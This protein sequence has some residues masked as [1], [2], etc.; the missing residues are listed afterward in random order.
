MFGSNAEQEELFLKFKHIGLLAAREGLTFDG[1][2]SVT[3]DEETHL[4]Q[5][6]FSRENSLPG[7]HPLVL[8]CAGKCLV[9]ATAGPNSIDYK[10]RVKGS[11]V[12]LRL[13]CIA[14]LAGFSIATQQLKEV[15]ENAVNYAR[16]QLNALASG[17]V[18]QGL[19]VTLEN[20]VYRVSA[21]GVLIDSINVE[22][23]AS[24]GLP[25]ANARFKAQAYTCENLPV[26]STWEK[27]ARFIKHMV[28]PTL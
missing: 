25:G 13:D 20:G 8:Q 23:I 16:F 10:N 1:V 21:R 17:F 26:F 28:T 6:T 12:E 4:G 7:F 22:D 27:I 24:P 5:V 11:L 14:T 2:R 18:P 15:D 19:A 9:S 3:H